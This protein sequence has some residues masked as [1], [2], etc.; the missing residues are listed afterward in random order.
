MKFE[1]HFNFF[2]SSAMDAPPTCTP[3]ARILPTTP[4][5]R[6]SITSPEDQR[7]RL[8]FTEGVRY[9]YEEI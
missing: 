4:G 8:L 2:F 1:I 9:Y 6:R 7:L 3:P 5:S